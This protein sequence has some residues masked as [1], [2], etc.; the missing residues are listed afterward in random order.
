LALADLLPNLL[1]KAGRRG[2]SGG[3]RA[4]GFQYLLFTHP[5]TKIAFL[6]RDLKT[7][8]ITATKYLDAL[9]EQ[10]F[11]QKE[12]WTH[13]LLRQRCIEPDFGRRRNGSGESK[14]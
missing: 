3:R 10:G 4:A 7:P 6:E 14:I 8:R 1:Q 12:N 11:L 13:E 2:D 5:Y 9:A